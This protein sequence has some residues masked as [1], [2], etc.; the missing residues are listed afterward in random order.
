LIS[1]FNPEIIFLVLVMEI[2]ISF[3]ASF[4][5]ISTLTRFYLYDQGLD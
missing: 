3:I 1:K 5:L 4:I 2:G